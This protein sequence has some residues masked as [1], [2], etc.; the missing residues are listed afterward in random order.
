MRWSG[1][2]EGARSPPSRSNG[3]GDDDD[4]D[5]AASSSSRHRAD[6]AIHAGASR[7]REEL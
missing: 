6:R 4:D 2:G 7:K 5:D 1:N 3:V